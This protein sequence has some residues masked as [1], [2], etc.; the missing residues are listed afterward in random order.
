MLLKHNSLQYV[1]CFTGVKRFIA[2]A[3]TVLASSNQTKKVP[4]NVLMV[5]QHLAK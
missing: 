1:D 4:K 3:F 2:E 5:P